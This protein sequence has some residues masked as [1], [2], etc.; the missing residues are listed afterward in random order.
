MTRKVSK[1]SIVFV[2]ITICLF[3]ICEIVSAKE[4]VEQVYELFNKYI[5]AVGKRKMGKVE[6]IWSHK[7]DIKMTH[8]F[9][10]VGTLNEAFGW[11][12]VKAVL[13]GIFF[14]E[15]NRLTVK[16]V[17]IAVMGNRASATFD[18]SVTLPKWG[19]RAARSC[20]LFREEKGQWLI[21]NHAWY[22]QDAPPVA[23]DEETALTKMVSTI[24]EAYSKK[25][26]GTLEAIVNSVNHSLTI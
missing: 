8:R 9:Q 26:L 6:E 25:D 21:H 7:K 14:A 22:I 17:V 11:K 1:A 20:I 24:K 18:Y 19:Q 15:E 10:R 16:N 23:A 2:I 3:S 12:D 13:E 4:D 5:S